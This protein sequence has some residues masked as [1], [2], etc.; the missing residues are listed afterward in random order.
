MIPAYCDDG[1]TLRLLH[2]RPADMTRH[3]DCGL[4]VT[5]ERICWAV[6]KAQRYPLLQGMLDSR[7]VVIFGRLGRPRVVYERPSHDL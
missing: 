7:P 6:P 5:E 2:P 4:M 3:C 1:H